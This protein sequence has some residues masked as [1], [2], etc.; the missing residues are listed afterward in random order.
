MRMLFA[1]MLSMLLAG[2]ACA[3]TAWAHHHHLVYRHGQTVIVRP[4]HH[5][6]HT[7]TPTA[8]GAAPSS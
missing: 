5:S 8:D 4:P 6:G 2:T 7:G 3:A 1:V